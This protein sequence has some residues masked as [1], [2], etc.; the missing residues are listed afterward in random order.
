MLHLC[1]AHLQVVSCKRQQHPGPFGGLAAAHK[2][3]TQV[4]RLPLHH[5]PPRAAGARVSGGVLKRPDSNLDLTS[6]EAA[7]LV[8]RIRNKLERPVSDRLLKVGWGGVGVR[9][10]RGW[11]PSPWG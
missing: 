3:C 2:R 1:S 8:A 10:G 9:D 4:A 5:P 6:P 11:S 7:P